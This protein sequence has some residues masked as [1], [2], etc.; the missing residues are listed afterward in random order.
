MLI[1]VSSRKINTV[2]H[3]KGM[4]VLGTHQQNSHE[5]GSQKKKTEALPLKVKKTKM[6]S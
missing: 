3:Q 4:N 1:V 2:L 5:F 6:A